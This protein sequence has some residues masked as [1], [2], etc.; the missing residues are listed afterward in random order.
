M[1]RD[2]IELLIAQTEGFM[3]SRYD[4]RI[5]DVRGAFKAL[6]P[7]VLNMMIE[8]ETPWYIKLK[9]RLLRWH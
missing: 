7:H 8:I 5:E 3:A 1:D 6:K 9:R 2:R 4:G